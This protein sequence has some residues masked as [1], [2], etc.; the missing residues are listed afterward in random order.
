MLELRP[1][2]AV[3]RHGR[4]LVRPRVALQVERERGDGSVPDVLVRYPRPH[5]RPPTHLPVA[6]IDHGLNREDVAGLHRPFC[7]VLGVVRHRGVG[8][9]ELPDAVTAVGPH[10]G[11]ARGVGDLF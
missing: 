7:L 3:P 10:D 1:A 8:V 5:T 11:A 4:P 9:E 2:G 6:H